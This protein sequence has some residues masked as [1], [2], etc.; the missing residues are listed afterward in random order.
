MT[1]K[2]AERLQY[3]G[4]ISISEFVNR[5][6]ALRDESVMKRLT[7]K[8][9]EKWLTDTGRLE[10]WFLG[11][12]P[13]KRLT[14]LGEEFGIVAEKRT[15]EKGNEYEVYFLQEEAQQR[16]VEWLLTKENSGK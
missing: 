15:S 2:M 10:L 14:A 4:K 1:P 7:I 5:I 8:S 13:R 6:N 11:K 9:V 16:I 3:V 12:S